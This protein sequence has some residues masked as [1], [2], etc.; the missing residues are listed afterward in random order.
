MCLCLKFEEVKFNEL[1]WQIRILR[2]IF[3]GDRYYLEL[4][5]KDH[6]IEKGNKI[7]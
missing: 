4:K 2:V 1:A 5:T 6:M 7:A 3:S